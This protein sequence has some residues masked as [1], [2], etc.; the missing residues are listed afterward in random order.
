VVLIVGLGN[1]GPQYENTRHNV[2]FMVID[3]LSHKFQVA[4]Q[5]GEGSF[6]Q[7]SIDWWKF[8][9]I[10]VKPLTYMNRSGIAVKQAAQSFWMI[11]NCLLE[12]CACVP[13]EAMEGTKVYVLFFI[14]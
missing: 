10:F 14:H 2:G 6:L 8:R 4:F 7:A 13:V 1:P 3:R 11:Y 5:Q 12:P 9:V